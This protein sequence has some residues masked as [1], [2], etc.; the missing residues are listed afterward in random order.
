MD[1]NVRREERQRT[2][3]GRLPYVTC[4]SSSCAGQKLSNGSSAPSS[5]LPCI[6]VEGRRLDGYTSQPCLIKSIALSERIDA[7]ML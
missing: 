2:S 5:E 4:P 6:T 1:E 7:V 3:L